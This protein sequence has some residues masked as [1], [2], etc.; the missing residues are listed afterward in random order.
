[1]PSVAQSS[2]KGF[3]TKALTYKAEN[4]ISKKTTSQKAEVSGSLVE[5]GYKKNNTSASVKMGGAGASVGSTTGAEAY[6]VKYEGST[7]KKI[8]NTTVKVGGEASLA[9][10]GV[11]ATV[12]IT[13]SGI[14]IG[15]SI[16]AGVGLGFN[17]E[18]SR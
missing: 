5:A 9:S 17:F 16:S 1:M 11:K 14:K 13:K 6:V 3:Y 7:S 18:I 10:V 2:N 4:N 8:G 12:K 15:G